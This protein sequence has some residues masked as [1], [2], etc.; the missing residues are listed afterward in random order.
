MKNEQ[1]IL[2]IQKLL[3]LLEVTEKEKGGLYTFE[4]ER[5]EILEKELIE[6]TWGE[7]SA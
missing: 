3:Y 4:K 7:E 6:L 1:R 2:E 5:K